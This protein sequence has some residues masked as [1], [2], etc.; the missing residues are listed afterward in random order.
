MVMIQIR[1]AGNEERA[2]AAGA[3]APEIWSLKDHV[4]SLMSVQSRSARGHQLSV[5]TGP[6]SSDPSNS[7]TIPS[8]TRRYHHHQRLGR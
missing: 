4:T 2:G 7:T 1:S 3:G 5:R 6:W 8:P